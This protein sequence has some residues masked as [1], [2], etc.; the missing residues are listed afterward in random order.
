M[1]NRQHRQLH[2]DSLF[3]LLLFTLFSL[4]LLGVLL[5]GAGVYQRLVQRDLS[6][7]T[8]RTALQYIATKL[9]QSDQADAL[10]VASFD[11]DT[12]GNDTLF[13]RE[14][15]EGTSYLTRVYV[16]DGY[17]R[18]LFAAADDPF[19]P[20]DGEKI[21]AA[22]SLSF[23]YDQAQGLLQVSLDTGSGPSRLTL[24]LRSRQGGV[25]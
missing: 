19:A 12:A 4:A 18:E 20:E 25:P 3:V 17:L 2:M 16:W 11:G 14:E 24:Y 1:S 5:T 8:Q 13:L 9:R 10:S 7:Y 15:I 22:D 6:A 21:L 23:T